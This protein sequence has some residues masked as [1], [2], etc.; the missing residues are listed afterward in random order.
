MLLAATLRANFKKKLIKPKK[1]RREKRE[2]GADRTRKSEMNK[3][4]RPH[5][6]EKRKEKT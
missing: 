4:G 3:W 2:C 6:T 5:K 1:H